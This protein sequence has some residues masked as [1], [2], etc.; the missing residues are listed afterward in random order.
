MKK[1]HIFTSAA[2][3]YIPKV[4]LLFNSLRQH[5]PEAVLHLAL[6]DEVPPGIDLSREPFDFVMNPSELDIPEWGGW[7]FCHSI[8]ELATAIKPFYLLKLLARDDCGKVLYLDPDTVT[9]SRLD[10]ILEALDEAS[11]TL[12][13]H[14][15]QPEADIGAVIDNEICNLKHGVFNLGFIGVANT[16]GGKRF[17]RWWADR[18]YYFCRAET[19]N[20]LFTDQKWID[21][22]P[23]LFDDWAVIRSPRHNVATWNLNSR[24][25]VWDAVSGYRVCGEPLGFYHFTGFDSG[26]HEIML[27]K[28][29]RDSPDAARLVAWYKREAKKLGG[30]PLSRVHWRFGSYSNGVDIE[31]FHR[32]IYRERVDLQRAFPYPFDAVADNSYYAWL[33]TQGK[34]EFPRLFDERESPNEMLR[35]SMVITPGFQPQHSS[36]G[37]GIGAYMLDA[38][39]DPR[40]GLAMTKK[41]YRIIRGEGLSGLLARAKRRR[42]I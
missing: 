24:P 6:A 28:Y 18:T 5:H 10:D 32:L 8:V 40:F 19:H 17:A 36:P 25:I 23:A 39:R 3:N 26:A 13:P 7:A 12:T 11:I 31:R 22:V 4:R 41:A 2:C 15:I 33:M 34:L 29:G 42:S 35:M 30:D 37:P 21:L 1:L 9:F 16:F 14:L 20:G 38:V 27:N